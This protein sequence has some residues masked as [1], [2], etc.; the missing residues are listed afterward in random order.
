MKVVGII[1]GGEHGDYEASLAHGGEIIS[2][3]FENLSDKYKVADILIDKNGVWHLGGRE[4]LPADLQHRVDLVWNTAHANI[5]NILDSLSVPH[6]S[7]SP[8]SHLLQNN[9]EAFEQHIKSIGV[10]M[11]KKIVFPL[12]QEDFDGLA[13][14]YVTKKAREVLGKF[15]APW[16]VKTYGEDE[17][18]GV[19]MVK[20]FPELVRA[21]EDG[22]AHEHSILVEEFIYGKNASM[23]SVGGYRGDDVY[24][25]PPGNFASHEKEQLENLARDLHKHLGAKH[26][27]NSNF[28]IH[29]KRGLFITSVRLSPDLKQ[30]SDLHQ[31]CE[32]VGAKMHHLVE[33][34]LEKASA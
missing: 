34:I 2:H 4:I 26:Y 24:V 23:H 31:A 32:F 10:Q 3:I 28:V 6:V 9:N 8:F 22:V 21:I 30:N 5:T 17:T 12:Y 29:P 33:H 25:F 18:M 13:D 20:T 27:L 14:L 7:V 15:S 16:I 19:H 1:R 11:P